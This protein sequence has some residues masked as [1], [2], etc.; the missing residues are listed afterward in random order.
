[1]LASYCLPKFLLGLEKSTYFDFENVT[2]E[3]VIVHVDFLLPF[4]RVVIWA[5][6]SLLEL[7]CFGC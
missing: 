5:N 7:E 6:Q 2:H 4:Y 1:M 3:V